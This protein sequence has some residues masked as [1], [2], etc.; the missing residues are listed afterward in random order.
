MRQAVKHEVGIASREGAKVRN[1]EDRI[2]RP[3]GTWVY[4]GFDPSVETLG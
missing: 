4:F 3:Y 2:S 1:G